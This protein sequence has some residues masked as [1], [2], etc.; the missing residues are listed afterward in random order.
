MT[1]SP[2]QCLV[3]RPWP[4]GGLTE[5][6]TGAYTVSATWRPYSSG[7]ASNA[8]YEI[9]ID[10]RLAFTVT[11]DQRVT[12]ADGLAQGYHWQQ[13]GDAFWISGRQSLRVRLTNQSDGFVVADAVR[14]EKLPPADLSVIVDD[15]VQL[16]ALDWPAEFCGSRKSRDSIRNPGHQTTGVEQCKRLAA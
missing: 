11:A 5:L 13:L 14:L 2:A 6:G 16:R 15:G 12:P 1:V 7:R 8:P 3:S 4:N 9:W 10:E